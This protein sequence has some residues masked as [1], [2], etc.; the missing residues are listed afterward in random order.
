[1]VMYSDT[2][3]VAVV[4]ATGFA[5]VELVAGLA[6]HPVFSLD[7]ITSTS[8]YGATLGSLYPTLCGTDADLILSDPQSVDFS[9][10]DYVFLAVP[11]TT[12]L[13]IVPQLCEVTKVV[14]LS[15]DYRLSDAQAYEQWYGKAHTSPQLLH[16]TVYALPELFAD[17]IS[18]S[19]ILSCPGCYPT[20]AAL[21][22]GPVVQKW[23]QVTQQPIYID[24]KSGVSGAGRSATA[25]THYCST[26]DSVRP[27]KVGT[28]QHT[29]EIEQ[30][31]S[32]L[33]K[34]PVSVLFVPHLVPM[35][36]GLL[37]TCYVPLGN[38]ALDVDVL[39]YYQSFYATSPFVTVLDSGQTPATSSVARTNSA[40]ISVHVDPRTNTLIACC[41]ID[42]LGKGAALQAIQV[43]NIAAG[44]EESCGLDLIGSVV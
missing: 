40:H 14:D 33:A 31:L 16:Q 27:Y 12:A 17:D 44:L 22:L 41:A 4:G 30:T 38:L 18:E 32:R 21:A 8:D 24:A 23:P 26:A 2:I 20:A 10:Y 42:N 37:V 6:K 11:H 43:A 7:C 3:S 28:H 5:G 9:Q 29:P 19:S 1:M 36:R 39:S 34:H 35:I 13:D 25:T 15:A